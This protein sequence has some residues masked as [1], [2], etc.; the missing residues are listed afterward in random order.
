MAII[1]DSEGWPMGW[2]YNAYADVVQTTRGGLIVNGTFVL[3]TYLGD[4][5][6][7]DASEAAYYYGQS[8]VGIYSTGYVNTDDTTPIGA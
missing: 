3:N 1:A 4:P 8:I 6:W 7:R 2:L 5:V